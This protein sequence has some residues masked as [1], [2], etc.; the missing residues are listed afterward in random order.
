MTLVRPRKDLTAG[1]RG[2]LVGWFADQGKAVPAMFEHDELPGAW[3]WWTEP[4]EGPHDP[5]TGDQ[6]MLC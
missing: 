3:S 1:Q 4:V 6:L 2:A 5:P